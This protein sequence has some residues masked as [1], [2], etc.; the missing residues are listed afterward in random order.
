VAAGTDQLNPGRARQGPAG[1]R[2]HFA[3]DVGVDRHDVTGALDAFTGGVERPAP[4]RRLAISASPPSGL[5]GPRHPT[6]EPSA[7]DLQ[8][9][10]DP[11]CEASS[12]LSM[13]GLGHGRPC[14]C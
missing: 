9:T 4:P 12:V 6:R 11:H 2:N 7:N 3:F 10:C 8:A 1:T 13:E 14:A 5:P